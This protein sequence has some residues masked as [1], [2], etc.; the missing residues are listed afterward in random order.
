LNKK[1]LLNDFCSQVDNYPAIF[2]GNFY[3]ADS[4]GNSRIGLIYSVQVRPNNPT[5]DFDRHFFVWNDEY[6]ID[7]IEEKRLITVKANTFG[8]YVYGFT[9]DRTMI[10]EDGNGP[11]DFDPGNTSFIVDVLQ[12]IIS[13]G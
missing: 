2:P 12:T 11:F 8:R 5:P 7:F 4:D 9:S 10:G 6:A 3:K 1:G 13:C